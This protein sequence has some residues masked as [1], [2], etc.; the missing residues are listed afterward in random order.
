MRT[1]ITLDPDVKAIIDNERQPGETVR[2]TINR[3]IRRSH[4]SPAARPPLPL[5]PGELRMD[6]SDVSEA[7]A[8]LEDET[9]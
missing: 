9:G 7:L 5:V 8:L 3:L 4:L 2:Q 1:T 6:I